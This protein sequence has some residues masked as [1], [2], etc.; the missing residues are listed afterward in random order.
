M[1]DTQTGGLPRA[2][3]RIL[4]AALSHVDE[5]YVICDASKSQKIDHGSYPYP[6][7]YLLYEKEGLYAL[8]EA[9]D[10]GRKYEAFVK[11]VRRP[12]TDLLTNDLEHFNKECV[13]TVYAITHPTVEQYE[14]DDILHLLPSVSK[15]QLLK[16]PYTPSQA[17]EAISSVWQTMLRRR[18]AE[19]DNEV[20]AGNWAHYYPESCMPLRLYP[21]IKVNMDDAT[22]C[23]NS[24]HVPHFRVGKLAFNDE[25][26]RTHLSNSKA[27]QGTEALYLWGARALQEFIPATFVQKLFVVSEQLEQLDLNAEAVAF[28]G[29][30]Q[31]E[32]ARAFIQTELECMLS[33]SS[34]GCKCPFQYTSIRS[35]WTYFKAGSA[36]VWTGKTYPIQDS[37]IA[38]YQQLGGVPL[39]SDN[40]MIYEEVSTPNHV[41]PSDLGRWLLINKHETD[42]I[43]F[44]TDGCWN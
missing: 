29:P 18:Y 17:I 28:T 33:A 23:M 16:L 43:S 15:L 27:L 14:A 44:L 2:L 4:S 9:M 19:R 30:N 5:L 32:R 12:L 13:W 1:S 31:Y 34:M 21:D 25:H 38:R 26:V 11:I 20:D 8:A 6:W 41:M 35:P 36:G 42:A 22:S 40:L 37:L 39:Y 3:R 7:E 24:I 10:L